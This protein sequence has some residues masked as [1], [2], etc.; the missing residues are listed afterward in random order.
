[1]KGW[2]LNIQ[3]NFGDTGFGLIANATLVEAD[4]GYD[5]MNLSQQ[6]VLV[7][8]GDSANFIGFYDK[9]AI[10]FE[11]PITGVTTSWLEPVRTMW[12]QGHQRMFQTT[13]S[14]I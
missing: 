7:G 5:N 4:V 8:L 1:M 13:P 11:S 12:V 3:H 2:E 14:G 9:T 10:R 6:F